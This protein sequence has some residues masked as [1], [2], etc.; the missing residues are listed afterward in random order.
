MNVQSKVLVHEADDLALSELKQF[1]IANNLIGLHGQQ[2]NILEALK[3]NIDLGAVFLYENTAAS[4]EE[5]KG[6]ASEI[7]HI[8][9]ELPIFLRTENSDSLQNLSEEVKKSVAG[10]Y[11]LGDKNKLKELLDTYLFSKHFPEEIVHGIVETT[12]K[13]LSEVFKGMNVSCDMPFIVKDKLIHGELF[14]LISLESDW[15]RGYMMF[16]AQEKCIVSMISNGKTYMPTNRLDFRDV[17]NMLSEISNMAWG[18]FKSRFFT[19]ESMDNVGGH[20]VEVPIIINHARGFITFGSD[21]PQLCFRY[22]LTDQDGDLP[23]V[24]LYQKFVFSLVWSPE[25][26]KANEGTVDDML[27]NGELEMF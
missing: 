24:T 4:N 18:G 20:R 11:H 14:S 7:H 15:C 12:S 23:P 26:Y 8:R 17:N 21:E 13:A 19:T 2:E 22:T 6:L 9:P 3:S 16:Q 1:C 10:A 5:N 27:N 25:N